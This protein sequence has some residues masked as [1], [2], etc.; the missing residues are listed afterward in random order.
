[1]KDFL[2][3][4]EN[5]RCAMQFFGNASGSGDVEEVDGAL[6]I[7]SGLDYGV[8]N[9]GLLTRPVTGRPGDLEARL[10]ALG[11]FFGQR[12]LRWSVWLCEDML[13]PA[14]RGR[15]RQ[16]FL[17]HGM[18]P[19]SQPPGMLA[20]AL[21]PPSRVLPDIEMRPVRDVATR[22]AF[23]EVTSTNFEIP[24][25]ISRAVYSR[26]QAWSGDYQGFVGFVGA[27]TAATVAI[28]PGAGSLGIYSLATMPA[29]RRK[30]YG[31]ALLRA[32]ATEVARRS[33][34]SRL[35]LQST[36]AGYSLYQRMGFREV[37]RFTVYL[38][39]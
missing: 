3:I 38:M 30:G 9:I 7:F 16:I 39:K 34:L 12:T 8:F 1:M 17:N 32:A 20:P 15:A 37:T 6:G 35:I 4:D 5:L 33:G 19:I 13:D 2:A 10:K 31:E 14:V 28:V 23:S 25:T 24:Y 11:K 21:L 18:R 36:D 27:Q 29:F 26:E 22:A